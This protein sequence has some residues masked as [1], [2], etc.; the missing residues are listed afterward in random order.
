MAFYIC[1]YAAQL[2][3]LYQQLWILCETS[4]AENQCLKE[5][6]KHLESSNTR[7]REENYQMARANANQGVLLRYSIE[8]ISAYPGWNF[9]DFQT[10]E[11]LSAEGI[12][13]HISGQISCGAEG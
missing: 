8:G 4:N 10:P 2:V 3:G 12:K 13:Y 6:V 7:L 1:D 5:A 11:E 9:G